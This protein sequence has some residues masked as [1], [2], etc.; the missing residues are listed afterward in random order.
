MLLWLPP[1]TSLLAL[2]VLVILY[3]ASGLSWG[4][5][6]LTLAA[7]LVDQNAVG[8]V[9]GLMTTSM[10]VGNLVT[11]PVFGYVVDTTGSYAYAWGLLSL[12]RLLGL[13]MLALL[14][15]ASVLPQA[16]HRST[17]L[18]ADAPLD[19]ERPAHDRGRASM[20]HP[21]A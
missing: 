8:L 9:A 21:R 12:W 10:H 13:G 20:A 2:S 7:E 19:G 18:H 4:V 15:G 16:S 6:Y 3:G 11:A 14:L 1:G 17:P 5:V